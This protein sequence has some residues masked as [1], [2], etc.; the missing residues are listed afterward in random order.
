MRFRPGSCLAK[1]VHSVVCEILKRAVTH[2]LHQTD[3]LEGAEEQLGPDGGGVVVLAH[4]ALFVADHRQGRRILRQRCQ[5]GPRC[6]LRRRPRGERGI[7]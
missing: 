4:R 5:N 3:D 1:Q 6:R 2:Q 7:G